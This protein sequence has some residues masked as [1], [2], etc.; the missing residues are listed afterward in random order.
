MTKP[1]AQ[2]ARLAR[3]QHGLLSRTQAE[4]LGFTRHA[5]SHRLESGAWERLRPSVYRLAGTPSS[6]HQQVMVAVL[7]SKQFALASHSTAARLWRLQLPS[8]DV[9]EMT[10]PL[11][12][13]VRIPGV[14]SH[15]SGIFTAADCTISAGIPAMSG[16]RALFDQSARFDDL[17]LGAALDDG[18]RRGVVSLSA[19]HRLALR[20]PG[21]AP[22]RSPARIERL[23][24]ARIPGY[25]PGDSEL[26][27]RVYSVLCEAG[28]PTPR[29]LHPVKVDGRRFVLDLAYP[30][31]RIAMEV[32][33]FDVHRTRSAFDADRSRQNLLVLA[34]WLLLRFTSRSTNIEIVDATRHALF[35]RSSRP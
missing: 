34:G 1:D 23:L 20:L 24:A 26:E 5:I 25:D 10:T 6:W 7:A 11:G 4:E 28:L 17:T 21:I 2:A 15:R 8:L 19:M 31:E 18:L 35:A 27:T 33:G 3:S 32:D 9:I 14:R 22:G 12:H 30:D 29:R 16:A 13:H